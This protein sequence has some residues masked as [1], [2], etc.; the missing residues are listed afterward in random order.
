MYSSLA[1]VA[2]VLA[3]YPLLA[4]ISARVRP[5]PVRRTDDTPS[6]TLIVP[7]HDEVDVIATKIE[8]LLRL[9]YPSDRLEIVVVDDGSTDGTADAVRRALDGVRSNVRL[10]ERPER[11]GKAA[12]INA[13]IAESSGDV[14]A[15]SDATAVWDPGALRALVQSFGDEDVGVVSGR[16]SYGGDGVGRV[17][18]LYWRYEDSIR[19]WESASGTTV[20]VNGNIFAIRRRD[21]EPLPAGTVN[22]ELTLALRAAIA[23]RRIVFDPPAYAADLPSPTMR[24]ETARRSRMTAGRLLS[25]MGPARGVWTRPGLAVRFVSHKLLRPFVP[26]MGG[27]ATFAALATLFTTRAR[28]I[29]RFIAS[30]LTVGTG[31]V[32]VASGLGHLLE[33]TGR[34]VPVVVRGAHLATSSATAS[35]VGILRALT[36]RQRATWTKRPPSAASALSPQ[37]SCS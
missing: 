8:N 5:R 16:M 25:T 20:G 7:C 21:A 36:G 19:S 14:S 31:S 27:L 32:A 18:D 33:R 35:I 1:G 22:D 3:G 12:A 13:A 37:A 2:Y 29:D 6:V 15:L 9:D 26:V 17:L 4:A 10:L 23:G 34:A 28:P 30:L 24:D 11:A